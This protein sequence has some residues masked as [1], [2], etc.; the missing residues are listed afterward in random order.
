MQQ[1]DPEFIKELEGLASLVSQQTELAVVIG[2]DHDCPWSFNWAQR[3]ITANAA[4]LTLQPRDFSR[5]LILHE[6]AHAGLTRLWDIV[7]AQLLQDMLVHMLLNTIEDCRIER[8]LQKRLPG[9]VTWIWLYNNTIF[10]DLLV[11][12]RDK[13]EEDPGGAFLNAILCRWWYGRYPE[14]LPQATVDALTEAWPH[15]QLAVEACPPTDCPDP[16]QTS[17]R[18]ARHPVQVCYFGM[19]HGDEPAPMELEI[20][21]A[22]H[23]M[24]DIVWRKILPVFRRLIDQTQSPL[25]QLAQ[26][27]RE[28]R[29]LIKNIRASKG[30]EHGSGLKALIK[31]PIG[32]NSTPN[33]EDRHGYFN[34]C[35]KSDRHYHDVLSRHHGS[36]EMI[37][38]ELLRHLSAEVNPRYQGSHRSGPRLDVSQAMQY[39]AN[40]RRH[41]KIWL[42]MT[43]PKKPDPAFVILADASGSMNGERAHATFDVLVML[44]ESCL[45]LG[46]PLSIF[47]FNSDVHCIQD[48][49]NPT[50]NQV[51]PKLC[52]LR[53]SPNGGTNMVGG[54]IE[55]CELLQQLPYHHRHFWLL[56]DGEPDDPDG[57]RRQLGILKNHVSSITALGLGPDTTSLSKLVPSALTNLSARQLPALAGR[58]FQRMA[59]A[60]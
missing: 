23:E 25:G 21:M 5:G 52:Q 47:M 54:L 24:W 8:W 15:I 45:R 37:T 42:R 50:S 51:V 36:I 28:I 16:V 19:D 2:S 12:A 56:S 58:F 18:Y 43:H 7:P 6:A 10:A 46:L 3:R 60:A 17:S 20:R 38:G 32:Q 34:F 13:L 22:Q 53:N 30:Q 33:S 27:L 40:P 57:A 41:D 59:R 11:T 31:Q 49:T 39:E 14:H 29:G 55:A 48:W 4:D 1:H 9:S 26:R 44:R 35:D